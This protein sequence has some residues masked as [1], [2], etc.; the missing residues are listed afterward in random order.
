MKTMSVCFL[1]TCPYIEYFLNA[2]TFD[3]SFMQSRN[4]IRDVYSRRNFP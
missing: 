4:F 1:L 2:M 3:S